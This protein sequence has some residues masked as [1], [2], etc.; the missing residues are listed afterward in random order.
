MNAPW[1]NHII[2]LLAYA[3]SVFFSTLTLLYAGQSCVDLQDVK[4]KATKNT[5]VATMTNAFFITSKLQY[6]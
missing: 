3:F 5:T 2:G 4:P 1:A 6:N